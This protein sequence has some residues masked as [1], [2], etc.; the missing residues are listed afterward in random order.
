MDKN[1][2]LTKKDIRDIRSILWYQ[3][4]KEG[5][6]NVSFLIREEVIPSMLSPKEE[7]WVTTIEEVL[8]LRHGDNNTVL[9]RNRY[10]RFR[11]EIIATENELS[12]FMEKYINQLKPVI[13]YFKGLHVYKVG[14]GDTGAGLVKIM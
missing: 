13:T 2:D 10:D 3:R 1:G 14:V 4:G 9:L 11:G 7:D 6:S 12:P 8:I 5:T